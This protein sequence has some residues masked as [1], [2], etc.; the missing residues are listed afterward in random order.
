MVHPALQRFDAPRP[1]ERLDPPLQALWW[2]RKGDLLP[3]PEWERAHQICQSAEGD[4][5]Y[6]WVHALA[7]LIEGDEANAHYWFRRVGE[8]RA[9]ATTAEEWHHIA[10]RLGG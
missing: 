6:D 1:P 10:D 5:P 4:K 3:G 9:G 8:A 2:L 7:H